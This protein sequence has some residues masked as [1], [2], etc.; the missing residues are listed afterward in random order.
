MIV[1][2]T[3]KDGQLQVEP[4]KDNK[5]RF[6]QKAYLDTGSAYPLAFRINLP[7]ASSHYKA[8]KYRLSPDCFR[9]GKYG[10]LEINPYNVSLFPVS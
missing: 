4:T 2:V 8:G 10:D 5:E 1:E 6:S 9:T 3:A 7:N